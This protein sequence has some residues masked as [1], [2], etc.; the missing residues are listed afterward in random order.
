MIL[1]HRIYNIFPL[2]IESNVLCQ[3][4]KILIE[5]CHNL[6]HHLGQMN[7]SIMSQYNYKMIINFIALT[8]LI[9]KRNYSHNVHDAQT[10]IY[11]ISIYSY[12][13]LQTILLFY[14]AFI[15]LAKI[16]IKCIIALYMLYNN[17][18]YNV[19]RQMTTG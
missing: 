5:C 2:E 7:H 19:Q 13:R 11:I 12:R 6:A 14:F 4:L 9:T 17:I 18:L 10:Y 15:L 1:L 8:L 3:T 16:Q